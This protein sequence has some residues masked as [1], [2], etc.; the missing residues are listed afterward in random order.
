[1]DSNLITAVELVSLPS[2]KTVATLLENDR[3]HVSGFHGAIWSQDSN[4]FAGSF[5]TGV[6]E[7]DT[8]VYR[9]SGDNFVDLDTDNLR[10]DV[11][12][13]VR[14]EHLDPIRWVKPGVLVCEQ[15][16]GFRDGAVT[17]RF[18]AKFDE[19]TDKFQIVSKK[20]VLSKE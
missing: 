18:T 5:S 13:E 17:Y 4:W 3:F 2:K 7:S 19:K 8:S 10:I 20:K 1:M 15:L 9:R 16:S 12:G 14:I 6:H 11:K